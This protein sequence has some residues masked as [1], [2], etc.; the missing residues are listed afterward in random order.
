[1]ALKTTLGTRPLLAMMVHTGT[2]KNAIFER[3]KYL[4]GR[5]TGSLDR[6]KKLRIMNHV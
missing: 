4:I 3:A 2:K 5:C 6:R 1:M